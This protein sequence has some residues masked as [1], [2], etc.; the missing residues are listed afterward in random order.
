MS[1]RLLGYVWGCLIVGAAFH[2]AYIEPDIYALA[3]WVICSLV[4]I[5]NVIARVLAVETK[6]PPADEQSG[7]RLNHTGSGA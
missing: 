2:S 5:A 1:G 3:F 7:D 6:S 4:L